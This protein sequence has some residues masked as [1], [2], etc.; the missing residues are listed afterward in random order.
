MSHKG[1]HISSGLQLN[2]RT[3]DIGRTKIPYL[4]TRTIDIKQTKWSF[5]FLPPLKQSP[6]TQQQRQAWIEI[7]RKTRVHDYEIYKCEFCTSK[8]SRRLLHQVC[9]PYDTVRAQLVQWWEHSPS[10]RVPFPAWPAIICGLSLLVLYSALKG[11][12]P[13]TQVFSSHQKPTFDFICCDSL[14]FLVSPICKTS[15]HD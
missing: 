8:S 6:L 15:M 12:S 1:H 4:P 14:W 7:L 3:S 2:S 9:H 11:F 5:G 10:I 13:G